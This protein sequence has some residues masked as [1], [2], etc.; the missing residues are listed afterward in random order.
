MSRPEDRLGAELREGGAR[1]ALFS[2]HAEAVELCLFD[3]E[4][5]ARETARIPLARGE[6]GVWRAEAEGLE[7]G[8]LYGFRV[9]GPYAPE[10]G[11]RFNPHKVLLD[12]YAKAIA[13]EARWGAEMYAHS[14]PGDLRRMDERDNAHAT[15]RSVLAETSFDWE[16]DVRPR[17]PWEETILY[18]LH[19]K[20]FTM[21]HPGAPE[22]L[23]GTY[24]GL[25]RP[26]VIEYLKDLGVTA[27]ELLP[28]HH[29][30]SEHRLHELG[31]S[32]YWGYGSIGFFAPDARFSSRGDRGGQIAEF[33]E[34]VRTLHRAG[35][36][37]ILD[38]VYGH[39]GEGD[40]RG[41][42]LS[43]RG[44][45]NRS[46]Y[47]ADPGD[48]RRYAD[49][50]GCGNALNAAHP[51]VLRLILD[52]LRY[53]AEEFRVDGFRFD[54]A[55]SLGR[56][57]GGFDPDAPF[58][59]AVAA[60]PLLSNLKLIA[61]PWDLGEGGYQ[62]GN[63]PAGWSEWNDRFRDA[64][65]R[66]WRGDERGAADFATRL[67]GSSD[68]FEARGRPPRAGVNFIACHDGFTLE[69]LVSF[70]EKRNEGNLEGNRDG[71]DENYSSN[72]GAEGATDAAC[73]LARRARRKRSLLASLFLA[74]G[75][76]MLQAGDEFGRSQGGNNNAYCQDNGLSWTD[77][78]PAE[79]GAN[80]RAFVRRL[81]R[82]RARPAFRR[83]RFF[84]PRGGEDP[85]DAEIVWLHE[86]GRELEAR[87]WEDPRVKRF[88]FRLRAPREEGASARRGANRDTLMVLMN[89]HHEAAPFFFLAEDRAR[90]WRVLI[91]AFDDGDE[92]AL[93][94]R[95]R[96]DGAYLL[97]GGS[98][99][100]LERA[101]DP[102]AAREEARP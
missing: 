66:F 32:N 46:Y 64:A 27:V 95:L 1:F 35:V 23:R 31:L 99:A 12:P 100:L 87:D 41:P 98:L 11:H 96:P 85:E 51:M 42:H 55:P 5:P 86:S 45:D 76:P 52:S 93:R 16:G 8:A 94:E 61:E 19:V 60:D 49:A 54:L 4:A 9:H 81:I 84:P 65:R 74:Q 43:F 68:V 3:P 25:A 38:V 92:E 26:A 69:D 34:M 2:E 29:R 56:G 67:A 58:F 39:A 24:S 90:E 72:G 44:I 22:R 70:R 7:A 83:A 57:A 37:V 40:F 6:G 59:R 101:D 63:F 62:L 97:G 80:L 75:V 53:W 20:G 10:E 71:A 79:S 13:G 73:V 47:R 77:W 102:P 50:T 14:P 28:V 17:T 82:L 15:P 21:R 30:V 36:E 78:T 18:E 48:M 89:A 88:G 33:K 91:D